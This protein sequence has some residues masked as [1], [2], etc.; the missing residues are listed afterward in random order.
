MAAKRMVHEPRS[1]FHT[2]VQRS[3]SWCHGRKT[4]SCEKPWASQMAT[5]PTTTTP[6]VVSA[7][8]FLSKVRPAMATSVEMVPYT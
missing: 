2:S 6:A 5:A 1:S 7:S 8:G 4:T 3:S